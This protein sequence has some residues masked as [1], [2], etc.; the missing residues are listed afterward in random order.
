MPDAGDE[1]TDQ[2]N[3]TKKL[4]QGWAEKLSTDQDTKECDHAQQ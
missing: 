1:V 3:G 4:I 2:A